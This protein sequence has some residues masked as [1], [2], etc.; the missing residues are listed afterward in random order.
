MSVPSTITAMAEFLHLARHLTAEQMDAEIHRRWP[1][2]T[3]AEIDRAVDIA[4]EITRDEGAEYMASANA[5]DAE[6]RR[7]RGQGGSA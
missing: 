4:A 3:P 7:R 6:L 1:S 5:L 2:A